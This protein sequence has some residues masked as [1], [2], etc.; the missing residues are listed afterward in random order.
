MPDQERFKE[1]QNELEYKKVQVAN[2]ATTSDRLREERQMRQQELEKIS[3]LEDKIQVELV[4]LNAKTT[5]MTAEMV[6]FADLEKLKVEA[7]E[8]KRRLEH[9]SVSYGAP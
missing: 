6:T 3:T 9:D 5:D 8:F 7:E 4:G 2:A 1:M